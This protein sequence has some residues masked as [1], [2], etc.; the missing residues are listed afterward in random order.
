MK[1]HRAA[2]SSTL[3]GW[4]TALKVLKSGSVRCRERGQMVTT[5]ARHLNHSKWK[6]VHGTWP[7]LV[8]KV[9]YKLW[10]HWPT[11]RCTTR[12]VVVTLQE[13]LW[14]CFHPR[15]TL[16]KCK[17]MDYCLP[18]QG[19]FAHWCPWVGREGA[20]VNASS[21]RLAQDH[22]WTKEPFYKRT[23]QSHNVILS[24]LP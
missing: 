22:F 6:V 21:G 24:V 4:F 14:W 5:C 8:L 9:L 11:T 19:S 2:A 7:L 12:T 23:P 15:R 16:R 20:M 1:V 10:F 18:V 17:L 3:D 13:W